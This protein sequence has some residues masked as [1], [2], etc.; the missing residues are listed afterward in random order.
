MLLPIQIFGSEFNDID[1]IYKGIICYN[2]DNA[3]ITS[4]NTDADFARSELYK[5]FIMGKK[6]LALGD[7]FGRTHPVELF[8]F[9]NPDPSRASFEV[10][11]EAL[12]F[13][14]WEITTASNGEMTCP[15]ITRTSL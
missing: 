13:T 3:I 15:I 6:M 7:I 14:E 11:F 4:A 10:N 8:F 1:I 9:K 2:Q 5:A 12:F